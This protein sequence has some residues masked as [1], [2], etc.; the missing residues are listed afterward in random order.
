MVRS[1]TATLR[2][3]GPAQTIRNTG[4][5]GACCAGREDLTAEKFIDLWKRLIDLGQERDEIL[6]AWIAK[7]ELCALLAMARTSTSAAR[8]PTVYGL[9]TSACADSD[10]PELHRLAA[11]IQAWWPQVEALIHTGITNAARR[12]VNRLIELEA[13][14]ACGFRNQRLRSRCASIRAS[15][16][17]TKPGQLRRP[18]C[19]A[20][21]GPHS[22]IR[23][24]ARIKGEA[25]LRQRRGPRKNDAGFTFI[26]F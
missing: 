22:A 6:A 25:M 16:R 10:I 21:E 20:P 13:R 11:T 26:E 3:A 2:G 23:S 19:S 14:N 8:F 12:G 24:A 9:S 5:V 7:E 17:R 1:V 15:W 18:A 4:C